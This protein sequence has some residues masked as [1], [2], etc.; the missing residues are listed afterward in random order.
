MQSGRAS[1]MIERTFFEISWV[2]TG[3]AGEV[4]SSGR[5]SLPKRSQGFVP[6]VQMANIRAPSVESLTG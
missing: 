2:R 3:R 6:L 4:S 1:V 5:T